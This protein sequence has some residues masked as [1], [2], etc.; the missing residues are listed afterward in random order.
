MNLASTT[1]T[2]IN[3]RAFL[4]L[5]GITGYRIDRTPQ[6]SGIASRL[7]SWIA[8]DFTFGDNSPS[9]FTYS[10]VA[11]TGDADNAA[12]NIDGDKLRASSSFDFETKSSYSVRVRSTDQGGLWTE[13]VFTI[14]VTDVNESPT[15]ISLSASSIAENAG[16]NAT[17]GT[18][19]TTDPDAANTFTYTLVSG[20]GDADNAA[21]NIDGD[22]LRAS[23]SFDFE[24]K[25]SYSTQIRPIRLLIHLFQ[26]QVLPI[27]MLSLSTDQ[28]SRQNLA[29]ILKTCRVTPY[30]YA[31]QIKE[32]CIPRRSL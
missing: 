25:S 27:T 7:G 14:S 24:T 6:A 16:T 19:T 4:N 18:L 8:D 29:S 17:I 20:T 28:N 32:V 31:Q 1:P 9:S 26:V 21:F 12:F 3:T 11:G 2:F 10:L 23:S 30:E 5:S 15:N 13:K 22:K